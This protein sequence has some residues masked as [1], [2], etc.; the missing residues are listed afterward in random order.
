MEWSGTGL[1][2]VKGGGANLLIY[3]PLSAF[4]YMHTNLSQLKVLNVGHLNG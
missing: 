2:E 1:A 4:V 3:R